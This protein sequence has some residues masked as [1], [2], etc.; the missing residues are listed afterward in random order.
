M[1]Q[2]AMPIQIRHAKEIKEIID[3]Q[4]VIRMAEGSHSHS[5]DE[6]GGEESGD[7]D[8][9]SIWRGLQGAN[10]SQGEGKKVRRPVTKK[11]RGFYMIEAL[12]CLTES[13][14]EST[15]QIQL[16]IRYM[17]LGGGSNASNHGLLE[18]VQSIKQKFEVV[19]QDTKEI[20]GDINKILLL[21]DR[22]K[23]KL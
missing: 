20:E 15:S 2:A 6:N 12:E 16:A 22:L 19:E 21:L 14:R 7:S 11:Q 3:A 1:G 13:N 9:S 10:P 5:E 4:E 8:T 18:T 17:S 23:D